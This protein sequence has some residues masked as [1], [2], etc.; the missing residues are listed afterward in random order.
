[1]YS[2]Q[3]ILQNV[4]IKHFTSITSAYYNNGSFLVDA[5]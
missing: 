4:F 5:H 2:S 3:N 1:M